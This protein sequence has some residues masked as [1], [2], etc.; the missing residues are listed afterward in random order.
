MVQSGLVS[1]GEY[2][3]NFFEEER[4]SLNSNYPGITLHRL[5]LDLKL[6]AFLN[7]MD[8]EEIF[9]FPYLP[10]RHNPITIFFNELKD[11]VP[12]EYITGYAYFYKS[13]FK[14]TSDVLIPR[15]ETEI[16]V[17][18]AT[19]EIKKNFKNKPCRLLDI[20]TGSGIIALS[21]LME[22]NNKIDAVASDISEKALTVARENYFNL[23]FAISKEH[24]LNFVKSD[25]LQNIEGTFD[26]ILT[27]PPYI[28][29]RGDIDSVHNQVKRF[30]PHMALF[31]DDDI[32][33]LWFEDLIKGIYD[34]LND[35][36]F[37]LIEGH[38][39]H[40]EHLMSVANKMGITKTTIIK[41]YTE[42]NRFLRILK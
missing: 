40:L 7:G 37:S 32:Y 24:E 29:R 35:G 19:N 10:H 16:L 11:G 15:S 4:T 2:L 33:D 23:R 17:E 42:R 6:H 41:D 34:R 26:I 3:K 1:L 27:N 21:V 31:L 36:G 13:H 20:G 30:E 14:V 38:E 39:N 8:F 12:L 5:K 18:I 9:D 28:K 22:C 25:R